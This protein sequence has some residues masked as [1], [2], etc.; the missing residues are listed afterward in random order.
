M[1]PIPL[2]RIYPVDWKHCFPHLFVSCL[3]HPLSTPRPPSP[4]S[5]TRAG[6]NC[7]FISV[8]PWARMAAA[9]SRTHS[10]TLVIAVVELD[11][12]SSVFLRVCQCLESRKALC[13]VA[14]PCT[15]E[16]PPRIC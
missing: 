9:Q 16:G 11:D 8:S 7:S 10:R 1:L 6:R 2:N 5:C 13:A 12:E 3:C 14:S 4:V 15:R